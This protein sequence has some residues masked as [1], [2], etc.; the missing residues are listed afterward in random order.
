MTDEQRNRAKKLAYGIL[1]GMGASAL[2]DQ[3]V[4]PIDDAK[5]MSE[6]FRT[7][8][9]GVEAW[10]QRVVEDCRAT[11]FVQTLAGRRR[12]LPD[13]SHKCP[14]KRSRAE[15]QAVNTLCQGSA[16]DLVK[17]AMV[18]V[19]DRLAESGADKCR[20]LLQVRSRPNC[21]FEDA[22]VCDCCYRGEMEPA[23]NPNRS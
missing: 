5:A 21:S 20:M 2:A 9:P 14:Q 23:S 13:I 16:A 11:T 3:L 10:V 8:L 1:Y 4:I 22:K 7:S 17:A 15:R 18:R 12:Y 6:S 19:H